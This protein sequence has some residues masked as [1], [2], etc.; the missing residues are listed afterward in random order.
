MA[1]VTF[2]ID[3]ILGG[4]APYAHGGEEGQFLDSLAIDP[5]SIALNSPS[6]NIMPVGYSK[7]SGGALAGAPMWI[8][9]SPYDTKHYVYTSN[10]EL[11]SYSNT[12]G[13]EANPADPTSGAGNGMAVLHDY[14]YLA[15]PTQVFRYGALSGGPTISNAL[16][17]NGELLDGWDGG[18]DTLLAPTSYPA[19]RNVTYPNHAMHVHSDGALY[20]CDYAG[21][22]GLIHK[23]KTT[24]A[25]AN[26][27]SQ[28]NVLDL[29][30]G[31]KPFD[32]DSFGT[33]LAIVGSYASTDTN[34]R[35]PQSYL[36]I[37]D[38]LSD[39]F[40]RQIPIPTNL[41]TS[42]TN[43]NGQL[44]IAAG[45]LDYGWQLYTYDGG[46]SVTEVWSQP[47]GSPPFAGAME[48]DG[49]RLAIGSSY[50]AGT[51]IGTTTDA[52]FILTRGYQNDRLGTDAIHSIGA[53]DTTDTGPII[54]ALKFVQLQQTSKT[55]IIGWRTA[56]P[57]YGISKVSASATKNSVFRSQVFSLNQPFKIRGLRIPLTATTA[58]GLTIV[59]KFYIDDAADSKTLATINSTN[60]PSTNVI[61]YKALE[62]DAAS[63]A[64]IKGQNN[65]F[66]ELAFTGTSAIG[67]ALPIEIT[68]ETLDD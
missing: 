28:Y 68:I 45:S 7:F 41:A 58:S 16:I 48:S 60:Y 1:L 43:V 34:I 53:A 29:P 50:N 59:P 4:K 52:A 61:T 37:W 6:G 30:P 9:T 14:I 65:F 26:D 32:I 40:Y 44:V 56:T 11:L 21:G 35:M 42:L 57:A 19:T 25:G 23:I 10:G 18:S 17:A 39:S 24:A 2:T 33:D 62:I 67:V 20:M 46:Y 27:G 13:S 47:S 31:I 54:S 5:E 66:L 49:S 8:A 12:L 51:G 38:T 55:P 15:T 36:F 3:S 63:T 64:G 22:R